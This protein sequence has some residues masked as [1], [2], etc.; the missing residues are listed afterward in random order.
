MSLE[1]NVDKCNLAVWSLQG[2]L[3][4]IRFLNDWVFWVI[5]SVK[6]FISCVIR[7]TPVWNDGSLQYGQSVTFTSPTQDTNACLITQSL[8]KGLLFP[9]PCQLLPSPDLYHFA[10]Y[11]KK[12]L[13]RKKKKIPQTATSDSIHNRG[14]VHLVLSLTVFVFLSKSKNNLQSVENREKVFKD[15]VGGRSQPCQKFQS[16]KSG[17]ILAAT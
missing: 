6:P 8:I 11:L 2:L 4:L 3:A 9:P 13:K 16:Q 17:W 1:K 15:H 7:N 10:F 14:K 12:G 5:S